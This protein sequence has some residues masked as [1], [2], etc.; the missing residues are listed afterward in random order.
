MALK[1]PKKCSKQRSLT[2]A[3]KLNFT[4]KKGRFFVNRTC[5]L[6]QF[7]HTQH[8][9]L[10][11][12][13]LYLAMQKNRQLTSSFPSKKPNVTRVFQTTGVMHLS[14]LCPSKCCCLFPQC[15][16]SASL[17]H[18]AWFMLLVHTK[19]A[20]L[21]WTSKHPQQLCTFFHQEIQANT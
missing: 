4:I 12:S 13:N 17:S 20:S 21:F 2:I 18:E 6:L 3:E 16:W 19:C 5:F 15:S 1:C 11:S 7:L 8:E 14:A 9:G 10:L